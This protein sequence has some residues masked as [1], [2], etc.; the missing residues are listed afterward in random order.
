MIRPDRPADT[1]A[2]RPVGSTP[3]GSG[4]PT[5]AASTTDSTGR[6]GR[7]SPVAAGR[8]RLLLL[9]RRSS[10]IGSSP[11]VNGMVDVDAGMRHGKNP[12]PLSVSPCG[13]D[14]VHRAAT[15]V[16]RECAAC[17]YLNTNTL[18]SRF[19]AT[20]GAPAVAAPSPTGSRCMAA[21]TG[22]TNT[23]SLLPASASLDRDRPGRLNE[24]D[25][26]QVRMVLSINYSEPGHP[27]RLLA[28]SPS[29]RRFAVR[30][31]SRF[32]VDSRHR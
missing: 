1:E 21:R 2:D 31:G 16:A 9:D 29:T 13:A 24:S 30:S 11:R 7:S 26:P 25:A 27:Q 23:A 18:V 19:P 20:T 28:R 12:T 10:R 4:R 3:S 15:A 17:D 14:T 8:T 22:P 32:G 6:P 5:H